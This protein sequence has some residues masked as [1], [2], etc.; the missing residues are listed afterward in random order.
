MVL[1][2]SNIYLEREYEREG[3]TGEAIHTRENMSE[4]LS[5]HDIHDT[6][7]QV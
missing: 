3:I 4:V 1:Y 7:G 2:I 6:I 5:T